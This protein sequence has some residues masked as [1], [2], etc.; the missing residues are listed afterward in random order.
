MD[1]NDTYDFLLRAAIPEIVEPEKLPKDLRWEKGQRK[2]KEKDYSSKKLVWECISRAHRDV[3]TG[4]NNIRDYSSKKEDGINRIALELYVRITKPVNS[5][6]LSSSVLIKH[7]VEEKRYR[8][9]PVQKLVNMTLKYM[10]LL[11]LFKKLDK[12]NISEDDCDCPLDS[13][14]L[15]SLG[16]DEIKW[17]K[18]FISDDI[19]GYQ[20]YRNI[21]NK[22]KVIQG[23]KSKLSYDFENWKPFT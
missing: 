21:Q 9:G 16:M 15:N 4:R 19:D 23:N 6:P 7:F 20:N 8:I 18:D 12:Y 11:Q 17:T 5:E 14:I 13:I 1:I 22:I 3:L 2:K 10:F